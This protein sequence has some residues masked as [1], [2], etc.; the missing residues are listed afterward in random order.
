MRILY[1]GYIYDFQQFGG[2]NRYFN[3]VIARL[4]SDCT[5]IVSTYLGPREFWP[6]HP[7]REVIRARPFARAPALA[8]LGKA[9]LEV[10]TS[11][12]KAD[13]FHPTYY[14]LLTPRNRPRHPLV[15]TVHD[16]IHEIFAGQ[17]GLSEAVRKAKRSSIE[18]AD[19]ILCNSENTRRDLIARFPE[20]EA[21]SFVTPLASSMTV[22]PVVAQ[23]EPGLEIPYFLYVGGRE[24]YKNFGAMLEAWALFSA[25]HPGFQ[26]R[27]VGSA[28]Q[29]HEERR[30]AELHLQDSIILQ[31]KIGDAKL[32]ILYHRSIALVYPSLYEGFG[33]PPLEAMRCDTA[34]IC[35]NS[36][37]LPEVG[38]DAPLY[39][40]PAEPDELSAQMGKLVD[41]PELR[42]EC[43][44][45]GAKRSQLFS[46]ENT[47]ALTIAVYQ[48]LCRA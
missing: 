33:I 8:F 10:R 43:R 38:G 12:A 40:D 25:R 16:M 36:S 37:S 9:W 44:R 29:P 7:R 19:A 34:V 15:V 42:T 45:R 1:D 23:A 31:Q 35:S 4:P 27:V 47:A 28:W 3:E 5:P 17:A 26:L 39:F 20:A 6:A 22:D 48:R 32:A 13:V 30:I 24:S 18:R 2:I 11:A 46:W 21:K 41:S 14:Q